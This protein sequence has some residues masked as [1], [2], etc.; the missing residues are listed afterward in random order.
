MSA[1][2]NAVDQVP[3]GLDRAAFDDDAQPAVAEPPLHALA[4]GR[5]FDQPRAEA[6][7]RE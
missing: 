3:N 6:A 4:T 1:N 7:I 5:P 2:H